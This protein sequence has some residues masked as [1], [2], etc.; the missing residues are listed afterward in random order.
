MSVAVCSL[1][2]LFGPTPGEGD[3][4]QSLNAMLVG[5][6]AP[7][8]NSLSL[9]AE[10]E[11]AGAQLNRSVEEAST[12]GW[13]G[14]EA[15]PVSQDSYRAALAFLE[16]F[17]AQYPFP[18]I[19]ADPDGEVSLEWYAG[20]RQT[21]SVSISPKGVLSYA[22]LFGNEAVHGFDVFVDVVPPSILS[23]VNR[24]VLAR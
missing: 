19:G 1:A 9:N 21:L 11:R 24:V 2:G 18:E 4:A 7:F 5:D 13:D 3:V 8:R 12:L 22:G 23:L 15:V 20:P 14:Y 10:R 16:A 6:F 17:P